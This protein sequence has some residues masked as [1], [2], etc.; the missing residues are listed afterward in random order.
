MRFLCTVICH[1]PGSFLR[2][3]RKKWLDRH[4][5][6]EILGSTADK[7]WR[8]ATTR[9]ILFLLTSPE[10]PRRH[11][12]PALVLKHASALFRFALSQYLWEA[13][14]SISPVA[15]GFVRFGFLFYLLVVTA[16]AAHFTRRFRS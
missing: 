4:S 8:P 11:G 12:V 6:R 3:A 14:R 5:Q 16:P 1:S 13:N 7:N 10:T 2:Y 9:A 15:I